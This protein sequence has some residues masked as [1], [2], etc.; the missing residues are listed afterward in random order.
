MAAAHRTRSVSPQ[1]AGNY[2]KKAQEFAAAM[3]SALEEK[4]WNAAALAAVHAAISA[5]DAMLAAFVGIRSAERDHRQI[6][7]LLADHLGKD[8]GQASK[9][10]QRVIALKNLVEYEERLIRQ[11][12]ANQMAAHVRRLMTLVESKLPPTKSG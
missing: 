3:E 12:E 5:G 9:H 2:L 4:R 11:A 10:V 1:A 8:G 7:T 6:V